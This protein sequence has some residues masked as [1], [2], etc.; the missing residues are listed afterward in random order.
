MDVDHKEKGSKQGKSSSSCSLD[1]SAL[2]GELEVCHYD[3]AILP[4][5]PLYRGKGGI[6][7]HLRR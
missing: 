1:I 2:K 5:R 4:R 6:Y 7:P 3:G